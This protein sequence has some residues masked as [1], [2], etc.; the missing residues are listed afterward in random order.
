[1]MQHPCFLGKNDS[2]KFRYGSKG[3]LKRLQ[4]CPPLGRAFLDWKELTF[5]CGQFFFNACRFTSQTAQVV[6]FGTTYVT[7]TFHFDFFYGRRIQLECTLNTFTAGNFADDEVAVQTAVTTGDNDTFVG[8]STAA[9]T[10]SY[11]YGNDYGVAGCEFRD[12]LVQ[13]SNFFLL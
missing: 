4:K 5:A 10:L 6:Q 13:T 2:S 12:F 3:R 9:V 8:L 11:A 7:T 1:M